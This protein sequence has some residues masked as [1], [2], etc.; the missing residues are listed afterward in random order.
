M[1]HPDDVPRP[2][3]S[4]DPSE[5]MVIPYGDLIAAGNAVAP[6]VLAMTDKVD[7]PSPFRRDS[8]RVGVR[9]GVAAGDEPFG[10]DSDEEALRWLIRLRDRLGELLPNVPRT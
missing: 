1:P 8:I 3:G 9:I 10:F 7:P 6:L 4:Y 5:P 2:V